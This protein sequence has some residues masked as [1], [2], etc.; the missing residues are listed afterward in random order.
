[1]ILWLDDIREPY[2]FED[3]VVW[4]KNYEQFVDAIQS[5]PFPDLICFDND[6]GEEKEGYDCAK[7]LVDYCMDNNIKLPKWYIQS[8]NAVARKN[9]NSLLSNFK[10][11]Q[12][13]DC[14]R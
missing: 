4:V 10:N 5:T 13:R 8:A 6:L 12:N 14:L 2:D 1:M 3:D 11:A 7:Y 9:I